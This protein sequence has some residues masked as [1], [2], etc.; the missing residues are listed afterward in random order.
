MNHPREAV[1]WPSGASFFENCAAMSSAEAAPLWREILSEGGG[2]VTAS[3]I[4]KTMLVLGVCTTA[5]TAPPPGTT[6]G[7]LRVC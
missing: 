1:P 7:V 5:A 2:G 6:L 4:P 3:N